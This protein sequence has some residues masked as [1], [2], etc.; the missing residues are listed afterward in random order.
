M[1]FLYKW[2]KYHFGRVVGT[3]TRKQKEMKKY[4]ACHRYHMI[5]VCLAATIQKNTSSATIRAIEIFK[6]KG[7]R[8][9][10]ICANFSAKWS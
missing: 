4:N 7:P 5:Y 9:R 1:I 8:S 6:D 2:L 3:R 10:N